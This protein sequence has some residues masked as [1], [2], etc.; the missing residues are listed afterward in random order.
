M[1]R[2]RVRVAGA[3]SIGFLAASALTVVA[4]SPAGATSLN[5]TM[6]VT[7]PASVVYGQPMTLTATVKG[8]AGDAT[9][10]GSVHIFGGSGQNGGCTITLAK[11][12]GSCTTPNADNGP[13]Q[14]VN[15]ADPVTAAYSGDGSYAGSVYGAVTY[16]APTVDIS[17][18]KTTLALTSSSNPVAAGKAVTFTAALKVTAPGTGIPD[19]SVL[20]SDNGGPVNG[21][22][23][24]PASN[25]GTSLT[26]NCAPDV[27]ADPDA[28]GGT[29]GA[30]FSGSSDYASSNASPIQQM[31]TTSTTTVLA[32]ASPNPVNPGESVTFFATV[33]GPSGTPT[34]S[35]TISA[36][37]I[38]L[39]TFAVPAASSCKTGP[40]PVG[41][42]T[43]TASFV[44][45]SGKAT[46]ASA[47]FTLT[48]SPSTSPVVGIEATPDGRG[49]WVA[50]ADGAV[51][52]FG[53]AVDVGSMY[54]KTLNAPIVGIASTADGQGYWLV[55]ADGGIFTFGDA[56]FYGST[57]NIRLNQPIVGMTA[58]PD[59]HGYYFVAS[60]GG[61]FSYGDGQFQGSMGGFRLNQPV[62]GM[63][64]DQTTGGY[65]LVAADGGVFSFN[66]A[67][68]GSTGN[69]RLNQPIV[70]MEAAPN[71]A[72]YRFVASDGGVFC[73]KQPF[74][75]SASGVDLSS[76]PVVGMAAAANG[77][78]W[79]VAR[80]GQVLA[81][82]TANDGSAT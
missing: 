46:T 44:S 26:W 80:N 45:S 63:A 5:S 33:T 20:F 23:T 47:T 67:F 41:F 12:T 59:G 55:A 82:G 2:I 3:V 38:V 29:I 74:D 42:D 71:G 8:P 56:A 36:A 37:G 52:A 66:A 28:A 27:A 57:G 50:R 62:V 77:G 35:V 78:Y 65:W 79:L 69:I 53:N 30:T 60:D 10:T 1:R 49:Y 70:G 19:G 16:K 73:F 61:V 18:A 31:V 43:V 7:A 40:P 34:G 39:C 9:P 54:G 76:N 14:P 81:E 21:C 75:G 24:T 32:S 58:T 22:S 4:T 64:V 48:V 17:P 72:G 51:S 68:D 6:T 13:T 25:N 15:P 11:G